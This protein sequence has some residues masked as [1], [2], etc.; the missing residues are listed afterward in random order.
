VY[1]TCA[2]RFETG[3]LDDRG[4][5]AYYLGAAAHLAVVW[6]TVQAVAIVAGASLPEALGLDIAAPLAFAG[7]LAK[8]TAGRPAVT[9]AA[10]AAIVATAAVDLPFQSAILVAALVG[11]SAGSVSTR[12]EERGARR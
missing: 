6:L 8:S 10:T 3:D 4:R 2:S 12:L 11:V 5:Q 1:F 7:L 9:A